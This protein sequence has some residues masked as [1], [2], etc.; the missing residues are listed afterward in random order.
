[1]SKRKQV[2]VSLSG[3]DLLKFSEIVEWLRNR[4]V[5]TKE[6]EILRITLRNYHK[7]LV[8]K[9]LEVVEK[10]SLEVDASLQYS[11][12]V[13]EN[14]MKKID[15]LVKQGHSSSREAF[16]D[17]ALRRAILHGEKMGKR[18]SKEEELEKSI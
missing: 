2:S 7:T 8:K 5:E 18:E 4:S 9:G 11:D 10:P 16:I 6:A 14:V 17:D 13:P 1:M 3:E 15:D 12:S